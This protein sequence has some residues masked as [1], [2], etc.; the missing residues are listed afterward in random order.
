MEE[1][2]QLFDL[3]FYQN[4]TVAVYGGVDYRE[5]IGVVEE[6]FNLNPSLLIRLT[7]HLQILRRWNPK[8]SS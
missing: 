3:Y 8:L 4:L 6:G 5:P 1:L 7:L 2:Y